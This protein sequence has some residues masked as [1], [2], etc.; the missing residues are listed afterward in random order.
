METRGRDV[1]KPIFGVDF[2]AFF[3]LLDA[4]NIRL[5]DKTSGTV[6]YARA[7]RSVQYAWCE[8]GHRNDELLPQVEILAKTA[9]LAHPRTNAKIALFTN[10]S[11][12]SI[13]AALQQQG[14]NGGRN[15]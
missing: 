8:D 7:L 10:A 2:L 4:W 15:R 6:P 14:N 12:Q 13:A 5:V 3:G 11:D 9:L 1:S